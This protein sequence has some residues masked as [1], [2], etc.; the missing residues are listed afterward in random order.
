MSLLLVDWLIKL[1][2]LNELNEFSN[3]TQTVFFF[4]LFIIAIKYP[5]TIKAPGASTKIS[6]P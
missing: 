4:N 5:N 1:I 2:E 3:T 6:A